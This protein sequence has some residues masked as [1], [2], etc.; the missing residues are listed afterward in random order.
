IINV[1]ANPAVTAGTLLLFLSLLK[2]LYQP[3]KD[4]SKLTNVATSAIAGAERIQEVLDQ[5]PEV[6]ENVAPYYGPQRLKGEITFENVI[7]GY[8]PERPIL[9]GINL[10]IAA[11]KKVALVGLSGGGKTTLVKLIPRF[12]EAQQ[13][14]VKIDGI[15]TRSIP[16]DLLR[17]NVTQVLQESVLFEGTILDNIKIGRPEATMEEIVEAAKQAHIHETILDLPDGYETKVRER[18]KN[19][20]GGQRQRLAIA[21]AILCDSPILILDEPTAALDVEAE[22]E[23]LRAI[24]TLVVGRTV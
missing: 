17:R 22:V 16:L 19:F 1:N 14:Y 2:Q 9:K 13:G 23:V 7:F 12:Y 6:T 8:T 15:D 5:A 3:M 10:H 21:R 18:G 11:G 24:D 4:L 20:S